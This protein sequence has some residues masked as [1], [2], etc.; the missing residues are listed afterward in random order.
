MLRA[1]LKFCQLFILYCGC[2]LTF[3]PNSLQAPCPPPAAPASRVVSDSLSLPS[4]KEYPVHHPFVNTPQ[5]RVRQSRPSISPS[6]GLPETNSAG[7]FHFTAFVFSCVQGVF[8]SAIV[9]VHRSMTTACATWCHT[10]RMSQL[11]R[12]LVIRTR[13]Q[14]NPKNLTLLFIVFWTKCKINPYIPVCIGFFDL[15]TEY[16]YVIFSNFIRT[17]EPPGENQ[18]SRV[19]KRTRRAQ[20]A[21]Y[22]ERCITGTSVSRQSH[23]DTLRWSHRQRE[24][25]PD[26]L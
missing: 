11:Q 17:E 18:D 22:G 9:V 21:Q 20:H 10:T 7:N 25:S 23:P 14:P 26:Q 13:H 4:Y 19:G 5:T 3:N 12:H 24:E 2:C 15:K 8:H 1:H 16:V 6:K